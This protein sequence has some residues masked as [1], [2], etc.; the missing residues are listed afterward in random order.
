MSPWKETSL[1]DL[2][3]WIQ[4]M[5]L[6]FNNYAIYSSIVLSALTFLFLSLLKMFL[7]LMSYYMM[8]KLWNS[9]SCELHLHYEKFSTNY[10][11]FISVPSSFYLSLASARHSQFLQLCLV[12]KF[13]N[14][15]FWVFILFIVVVGKAFLKHDA[16]NEVE[17]R[18]RWPVWITV[19]CWLSWLSHHIFM[20]SG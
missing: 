10:I 4:Y 15:W 19:E 16:K 12:W 11:S 14:P 8:Y 1:P 2:R 17:S 13:P 18:V 7:F 3:L 5:S 9:E 6:G 20:N